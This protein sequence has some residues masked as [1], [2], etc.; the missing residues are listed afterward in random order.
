MKYRA[1]FVANSSSS[2]FIIGFFIGD[3]PQSVEDI[4]RILFQGKSPDDLINEYSYTINVGYA[5]AEIWNDF[6]DQKPMTL[7]GICDNIE[8]KYYN[9]GPQMKDFGGFEKGADY[10]GYRFAHGKFLLDKAEEI[11]AANKDKK[12]FVFEYSDEG[13]NGTVMEH[14]DIFHDA[15][16]QLRIS[17]H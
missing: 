2:S 7:N 13:P 15:P 1:G 14:G 6:K 8:N 11:V 16:F 3:I 5:C 9:E 17:N 12:L 10:N 4:Q